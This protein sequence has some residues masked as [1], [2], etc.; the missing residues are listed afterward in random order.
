MEK[1]ASHSECGENLKRKLSKRLE[2]LR[3]YQRIK[4]ARQKFGILIKHN[5]LYRRSEERSK[6]LGERQGMRKFNS[7]QPR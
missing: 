7:T 5:P 4:S 1:N 3:C 6:D 2:A